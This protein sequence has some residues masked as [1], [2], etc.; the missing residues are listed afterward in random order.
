MGK[1]LIKSES[2]IRCMGNETKRSC[3]MRWRVAMEI[4]KKLPRGAKLKQNQSIK[5]GR[6]KWLVP[7]F[8]IEYSGGGLQCI[9][10]GLAGSKRLGKLQGVC[11]EVIHVS[12]GKRF[13]FKPLFR[14]RK[15]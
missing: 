6:G 8:T 2:D 13:V 1:K 7:D 15:D 3:D 11:D 12:R 14:R 5:V 10:I 9:E 4:L